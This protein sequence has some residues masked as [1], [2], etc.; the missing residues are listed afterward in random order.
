MR[1]G[2]SHVDGHGWSIVFFFWHTLLATIDN[3]FVPQ[4]TTSPQI[5]CATT[6]FLLG[7]ISPC[8]NE[9]L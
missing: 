8:M 1:V 2:I 3:F 9:C 5:R 7:G 4:P 6:P